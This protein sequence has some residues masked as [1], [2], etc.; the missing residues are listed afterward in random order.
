[1]MRC[2]RP[3]SLTEFLCDWRGSQRIVLNGQ[4][5]LE[6]AYDGLRANSYAAVVCWTNGPGPN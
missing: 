1:M 6:C 2:S 5:K 4:E 3:L